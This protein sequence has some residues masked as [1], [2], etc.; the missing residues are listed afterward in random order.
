MLAFTG[1]IVTRAGIQFPGDY[2]GVAYADIP[3]GL[4]AFDVMPLGLQ[5]KIWATVFFLECFMRSIPDT[6]NEIVGDYR[7]G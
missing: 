7:N 6:G 2:E 4:V 5:A 1:Q 3:P